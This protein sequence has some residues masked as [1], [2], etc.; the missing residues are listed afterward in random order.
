MTMTEL[1]TFVGLCL[2]ILA[3]VLPL[4]WIGVREETQSPTPRK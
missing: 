4:A 2:L 1:Y 3:V